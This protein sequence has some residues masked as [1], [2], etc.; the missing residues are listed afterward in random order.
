[1]PFHSSLLHLPFEVSGLA[2]LEALHLSCPEAEDGIETDVESQQGTTCAAV[3][4]LSSE[5]DRSVDQE[6]SIAVIDVGGQK[7]HETQH[8]GVGRPPELSTRRQRRRSSTSSTGGGWQGQA[9]PTRE[10]RG[11]VR[12]TPQLVEQNRFDRTPSLE[13]CESD[14]STSTTCSLRPSLPASPTLVKDN[15]SAIPSGEHPEPD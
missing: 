4:A 1:M 3:G 12:C 11:S 8:R 9:A 5:I 2:C 6:G 15:I 13:S 7:G 14:V 10:R